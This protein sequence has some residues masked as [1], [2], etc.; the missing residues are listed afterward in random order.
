MTCFGTYEARERR[1]K[2]ALFQ[3]PSPALKEVLLNL[4]RAEKPM[5]IDHHLCEIGS[6]RYHIESSASDPQQIHLS[7]S[8]PSLSQGL[9]ISKPGDRYIILKVKK[10]CPGAVDILDSAKAGYQLTVE[11]NLAQ[12]PQGKGPGN[13]AMLIN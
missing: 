2:V 13:L 9:V 8:I 10:I 1:S 11:V 5:N 12:I 6:V 3:R 4:H 7:M